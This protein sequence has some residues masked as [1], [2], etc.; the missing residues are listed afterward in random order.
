MFRE[1]LAERLEWVD[2]DK[3]SKQQAK[4]ARQYLD[5]RDYVRAALFGWESLVTQECERDEELDPKV[6]KDR[7]A[8]TR[9]K[10]VDNWILEEEQTREQEKLPAKTSTKYVTL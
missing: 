4:L 9:K 3:L 6:Y 5:R 8:Q 7:E 1:R 10:I 2:L